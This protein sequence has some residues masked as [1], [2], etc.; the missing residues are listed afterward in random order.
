[1]ITIQS[2]INLCG[3]CST[4]MSPDVSIA[5]TVLPNIQ[6][7]YIRVISLSEVRLLLLMGTTSSPPM[8][9][10]LYDFLED[11]PVL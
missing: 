11:G 7:K 2:K 9:F 8:K 10:M 3:I 5:D 6:T 4:V 1:M